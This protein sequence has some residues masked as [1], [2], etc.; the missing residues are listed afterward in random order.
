MLR[1]SVTLAVSIACFVAWI[2]FG[3]VVPVGGGM[4]HA[5]LGVSAILF[6]RWWG[7]T[8]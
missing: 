2:V 8:R 6:V 4:V 7:L 5:L 1:N 3:F